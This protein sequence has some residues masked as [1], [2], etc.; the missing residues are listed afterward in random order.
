MKKAFILVFLF[1]LSASC[2]LAENTAQ[3]SL[4]NLSASGLIWDQ[5]PV[6]PPYAPCDPSQR[7]PEES[8]TLV[9]V[10]PYGF[11]K[12]ECFFDSR[13]V[14]GL[15]EDTL[16]LFPAPRCLDVCGRDINAHGF[17]NM[18]GF[19]S[20]LGA[21]FWGPCW[22]SCWTDGLIEGDFRGS[23]QTSIFNFR[24]RN[25]LARIAWDTGFLLFGQW[26][27]PLWIPECY[28]HTLS[29]G[30]GAPLDPQARDPQITYTQRFANFEL[31]AAILS[32]SEY[33]NDGPCGRVPLYIENAVVPNVHLQ[34]R[35]YHGD[36]LFGIAGD[37]KRIVPRLVSDF[38]VKAH[39]HVDS[40]IVEGFASFNTY[41]FF[42]HCKAYWAQNGSDQLLISGYGVKCLNHHT[43]ER[44]YS[45][46]ACAG[47]W[48]DTYYRFRCDEME[49]GLFVGGAKNLGS[50]H[51]LYI[52]PKTCS[53][54]IYALRCSQ[55]LDYIIEVTP[56]F[57]YMRDP[58]RIGFEF[59]YSRASWGTTNNFGKVINGCPVNDFRTLIVMYYLF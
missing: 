17:W 3:H 47:A 11:V 32:Q 2:M 21:L 33:A 26:W 44:T 1:T 13:Q 45:P 58:F 59:Q 36:H 25:A 49:L 27:H 46:T 42:F 29:Y 20:R 5:P 16:F 9:E 50:Q 38:C 7:C 53:P 39:E 37:Y 15:F 28:P 54:I 14:F 43:D 55:N 40:F 57:V 22:G 6:L 31:I 19:E 30:I 34:L 56:R 4:F 23:L 18:T 52:D 24:L 51:E 41:P 8:T 35:H 48:L 12:W 10:K